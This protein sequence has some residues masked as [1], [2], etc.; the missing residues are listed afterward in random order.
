MHLLGRRK[1]QGR[2][3]IVCSR[4]MVGAGVDRVGGRGVVEMSFA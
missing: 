1:G 3:S 2:V 4:H